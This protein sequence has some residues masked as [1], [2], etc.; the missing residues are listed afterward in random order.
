MHIDPFGVE[1]WMNAWET[2]CRLN[3]AETCVSAMT[4]A[5]LLRLTGR[6]A[7]VLSDL[8]ETPLGYGA[9]LGSE[10]LRTAIAAL[11]AGRTAEDVLV[12]H[13]TIGANDLAWRALVG[14]GDH[15]VS[16]V[17]TYQQHVSIPESLGAEVTRL[18]LRPEDGY[19]PDISRL[20]AALRPETRVVA[21]TNPNNPTGSLMPDGRLREI[22]ALT[23]AAARLSVRLC[24]A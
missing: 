2:R 1:I 6:N 7:D 14:P 17:P 21:F 5:E 12:T 19:L 4:L 10:R 9:I 24:A 16:M 23:E 15:V 20:R 13:G 8:M 22:V 18:Q 11:Y 3:L